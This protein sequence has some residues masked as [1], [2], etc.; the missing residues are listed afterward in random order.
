MFRATL[1]ILLLEFEIRLNIEFRE[2]LEDNLEDL[3][4]ILSD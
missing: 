4:I 2:I 3:F 1:A